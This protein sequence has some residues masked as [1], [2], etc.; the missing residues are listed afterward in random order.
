MA[1]G[2]PTSGRISSC[3]LATVDQTGAEKASLARPPLAVISLKKEEC[4]LTTSNSSS[5]GEKDPEGKPA[6]KR[7]RVGCQIPWLLSPGP[8][9]CVCLDEFTSCLGP[10]DSSQILPWHLQILALVVTTWLCAG[11][12]KNGT[13]LQLEIMAHQW[14]W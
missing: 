9:H 6:K 1:S 10:H 11:V 12:A 13:S 4:S 14:K 2:R 7:A 3:C 5:T 8:S